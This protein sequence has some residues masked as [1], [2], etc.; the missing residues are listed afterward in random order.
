MSWIEALRL[1]REGIPIFPG[2]AGKRPLI[3]HGFKAASADPDQVHLWWTEYPEALIGVPTGEKFVVVD[4]DLQHTEALAWY[5]DHR[6][7]LLRGVAR[8]SLP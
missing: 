6:A 3:Q 4:L 7:D 8:L 5:D 1:A 2:G